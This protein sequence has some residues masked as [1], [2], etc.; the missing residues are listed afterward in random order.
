LFVKILHMR[1]KLERAV[2]LLQQIIAELDALDPVFPEAAA[3]KAQAG[4][5]L[6]CGEPLGPEPMRGCHEACYHR[7]NTSIRLGELT[8][9]DAIERGLLAPKAKPGRKRKT[10]DALSKVL[11]TQSKTVPNDFETLQKNGNKPR[12]PKP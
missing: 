5:C 1:Q 6:N 10:D 3:K 7:I 8:E 4:L 9:R 11:G 12:K 2:A